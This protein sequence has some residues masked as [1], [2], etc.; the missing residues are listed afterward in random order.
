MNITPEKILNFWFDELSPENW[1]SVNEVIDKTI[2]E[3]F[4]PTLI[5][6]KQGE[7]YSWRFSALGRLAE[8]I[9]L[10][11][12]SR[13]IYRGSAQAFAADPMALVLA[14]EAI[15]LGLDQNLEN[16]K[17]SFL[18][19]PYMHSE[20]KIIHQEA[21]RLYTEL[22]NELNLEFELKHKKIIDEFGRYPH[23]NEI[24]GRTSTAEEIEFLKSPDSSF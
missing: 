18:Y 3:R 5:A 21:L 16:L 11:Q 12:F 20:S 13:N 9:V 17:K 14:Q 24:L 4:E 8:I 6:A 1:F 2:K 10:D 22:G 19:L 23:R 15:D 7:L